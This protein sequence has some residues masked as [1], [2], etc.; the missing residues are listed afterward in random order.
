MASYSESKRR[1][2]R[3]CSS[4]ITIVATAPATPPSQARLQHWSSMSGR[5]RWYNPRR[6]RLERRCAAVEVAGGTR[7]EL[8]ARGDVEL[9]EALGQ[10]VSTVRQ[11]T[12]RRS[13]A[14]RRTCW[15]FQGRLNSVRGR[16]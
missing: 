1:L 7:A 15:K 13:P 10:G 9:S 6:L 4:V 14:T 3:G 8:V 2:P 16:V 11:S 5:L 12:A